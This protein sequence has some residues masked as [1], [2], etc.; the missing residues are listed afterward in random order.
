LFEFSCLVSDSSSSQNSSHMRCFRIREARVSNILLNGSGIVFP[1]PR[2]TSIQHLVERLRHCSHFNARVSILTQHL[3]SSHSAPLQ[4]PRARVV[5]SHP[6]A[7]LH[8][9]IGASLESVL[10][11]FGIMLQTGHTVIYAA[12]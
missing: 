4:A 8:M 9:C 10:Q 5:A 6:I 11:M 3:S 2:G 12:I 7:R 1:H